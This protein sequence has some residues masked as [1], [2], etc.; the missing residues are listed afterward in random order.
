[1]SK[2]KP[3]CVVVVQ[4]V[5]PAVRVLIMRELM[6]KYDMRKTDAAAKM[7]LTPAAITQY[8]KGDRGAMLVSEVTK[9]EEAMGILSELCKVL[10][11]GTAPEE[12][13]IE[14]L[15]KACMTL[16]SKG[17]CS[18]PSLKRTRR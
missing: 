15:C 10:V 16:R 17:I 11:K 14:K 3:P 7:K 6:E 8:V 18:C 13:V 9:S 12:A 1:M 4:Y 2:L 5:L